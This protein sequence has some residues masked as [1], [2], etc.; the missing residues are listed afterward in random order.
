M[1]NVK[2][3]CRL[4]FTEIG[5]GVVLIR[6]YMKQIF[7]VLLL[8]VN[9]A[10]SENP[11][12]CRNCA[13]LA[14]RAF[15]FK[16][17]CISTEGIILSYADAKGV[18]SLDMKWI[19]HTGMACE[20]AKN[21]NVC[22]FC[23]TCMEE[24]DYLCLENIKLPEKWLEQFLPEIEFR[25]VRP[26]VCVPCVDLLTN[27][28]KFASTS[29]SVEEILNEYCQQEG[30]NSNGFVNFK[31]VVRFSRET[32]RRAVTCSES[33]VKETLS[34][35]DDTDFKEIDIKI[36]EHNLKYEVG[37]DLPNESERSAEDSKLDLVN[38]NGETC[39]DAVREDETNYQSYL[40]RHVAVDEKSADVEIYKCGTCSF[41]AK[42]KAI[43]NS[44][45]L[46]HSSKT[47]QGD[48]LKFKAK[49]PDF[50]IEHPHKHSGVTTSSK[51][52][53]HKNDAEATMYECVTCGF[54]TRHQNNLK[55]HRVLHKNASEVTKYKC[56]KCKFKTKHKWY[57][58]THSLVH[59]KASEVTMY[60]CCKCEFKTKHKWY[61][62][63][64]SLVHKQ[65]SEVTMYK[66]CKCEFKTKRQ[67]S[68]KTHS[69][70][71]K[72]ASERS[73]ET[74]SLIHKSTSEVTMY[75]CSKCEYK[76]KYQGSL[77]T[78]SL[79]H[80]N[81][82]DVTMYKCCKCEFK[83]RDKSNFK[84]HSLVHK[85]ASETT[86][87][88]CCKCEYT[89]KYQNDLKKH[90]LVH[91]N[92]S[93][94]TMYKCSKCEF[95]TKHQTS[96]KSHSLLHKKTSELTIGKN[97]KMP[98]FCAVV[99][100]SRR[101]ERDEVRFF[102]IPKALKNRGERLDALSKERRESWVRALKRGNLS[103]IFLNNARICANHFVSGK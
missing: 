68:L 50:E 53:R 25:V 3:I 87:Y 40:K 14:W 86:M 62:K 78:H 12:I 67:T 69:L 48:I 45:R 82:S 41:T 34:S 98:S 24:G 47:L 90:S 80:K 72:N 28:F 71:H 13:D 94:L 59:K 97:I 5:G 17:R 27:Y 35:D 92:A 19:Y 49:H 64:H 15:T 85:K 52:Q 79:L 84:R 46:V 58:K 44:H 10:V 4:C 2:Y 23:M 29:A 88:K 32:A 51:C 60:K 20:V 42:R 7:E 56:C 33:I 101:A 74:H 81:A 21:I 8:N 103:D 36:E 37:I 55:R 95:K 18:T 91:K 31:D 11:V 6:E 61:L 77:E 1:Q 26:V 66:C 9:F 83:T 102:K 100:C 76:T 99:G 63:T 57:L 43:I 22:R 75:K 30:T 16:S 93:E 89:T 39:G 38:A 70:V 65:A 96:F 73:L 54:K